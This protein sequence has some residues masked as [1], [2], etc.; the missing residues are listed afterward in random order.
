MAKR[1]VIGGS[2]RLTIG[3]RADMERFMTAFTAVLGAS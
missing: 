2:F 1:P 3:T